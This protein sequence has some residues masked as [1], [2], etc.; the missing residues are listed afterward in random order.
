MGSVS[1]FR[2]PKR[3]HCQLKTSRHMAHALINGANQT[4]GQALSKGLDPMSGPLTIDRKGIPISRILAIILYSR[5]RY[6]P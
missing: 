1:N 2:A 5:T 3:K 6:Y 4:W